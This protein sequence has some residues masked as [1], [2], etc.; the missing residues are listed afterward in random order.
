MVAAGAQRASY[1]K[2]TKLTELCAVTMSK[3]Q[4]IHSFFFFFCPA[5]DF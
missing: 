5:T 4:H 3:T 1:C 2:L